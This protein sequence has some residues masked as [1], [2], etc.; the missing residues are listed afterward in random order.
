M[1]TAGAALHHTARGPAP[2]D[3]STLQP[4]FVPAPGPDATPAGRVFGDVL[5]QP[6]ATASPGSR[7]EVE[8]VSAH[9]KH[10]PRRNST[11]L[12]VQRRSSS[13]R[14]ERVAN[15]GEWAVRFHWRSPGPGISLVRF[16]WDIPADA[17]PGRY[18]FQHFA[19]RLGTDGSLTPI[20]GTSNEFDIA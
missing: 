4:N 13:G 19:D 6:P 20:T 15:E 3:V 7:I 9:P 1:P 2:R 18:R 12:E 16:T 14:W 5:V 8:F 17:A 11:F 10:N